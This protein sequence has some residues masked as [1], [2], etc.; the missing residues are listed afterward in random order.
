M[1]RYLYCEPCGEQAC[2][3]PNVVVARGEGESAERSRWGVVP[4][5]QRAGVSAEI[6]HVGRK[7]AKTAGTASAVLELVC[8]ACGSPIVPGDRICAY[9]VGPEVQWEARYCAG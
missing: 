6:G 2:G 1:A 3:G 4:A 5:P 8:D 9:S 7:P